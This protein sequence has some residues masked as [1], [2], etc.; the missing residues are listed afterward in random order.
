M[1][2]P[3]GKTITIEVGNDRNRTIA[4]TIKTL[5]EDPTNE[6]FLVIPKAEWEQYRAVLSLLV[7]LQFVQFVSKPTRKGV[8]VPVLKAGIK[9]IPEGSKICLFVGRPELDVIIKNSIT[10]VGNEVPEF[11][12]NY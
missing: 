12:L 3:N 1:V 9:H 2:D 6:I 4:D 8:A 5:Q 7:D 10:L 11:L